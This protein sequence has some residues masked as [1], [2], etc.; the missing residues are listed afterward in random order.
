M[1][2]PNGAVADALR[3]LDAHMGDFMRDLS[4][5]SRIPSVS[6][7][8]FPKEEVRRSAEATAEALRRARVDNVRVLEIPGVH[9]YAYGEWL[10][11]PG[12][13]TILLYGHHDVQPPG[14]PEKWLSPPFEPTERGGRL[15]GRGTADDKGGVMV[16]V[17][18]VAAYLQA[19]GGLP[20]NIKFI[21]EGEEEIGS[22][23]LGRFLTEYRELMAADF[24]V[25]TD[26][27]N[28]DTGIPA[29]T[30]QLRGICQVDV[31]VSCLKQPVHS[32]AWGGPVPDAVQILCRLVASLT[33]ADGSLDVPGLYTKVAKPSARQIGRIR[34]LPFKE[35]KYK[36]EAGML[37]GV[38][39]GGEKRFSVYERL[40]TRPALTVIA[41]EARPF[42]GSS[43]Q[44]I[45][46]ARA[47]LSLRT[48][49]GMNPREAARLLVKRLTT[50][51]PH[52][53]RVTARET[54]G[55]PAWTTD[56]EGPAFEAAR[57]ALKA[58]F[59]REAVMMGCGGSIG[60]VEPFARVLGGVPCLLT[61]VADPASNAHSE[62]E[63]LHLGDW[64]RSMRAAVHLYDELA[65]VPAER[66]GRG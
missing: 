63:S 46:A 58:G 43:N 26:T 30:Y 39:L 40:W 7:N 29:L 31:E 48:V 37:P 55:T 35:A 20:C 42:L 61:G 27:A 51:P 4:E 9:P 22:Q 15:Y 59:G 6:A 1:S 10:K 11:R 8:G 16:H 23:N 24:I 28:F 65:R 60:F 50:K 54:G 33:K 21:V 34:S 5:L 14:R 18:A 17:A 56:P 52:G 64:A 25:L 53:A 32:G 12:A 62:N 38:R 36:K 45:E 49:P 47:R 3:Y 2:K 57:R 19:A 41:L 44:I 66:R 13:P